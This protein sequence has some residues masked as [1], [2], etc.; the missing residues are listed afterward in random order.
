MLTIKR[1]QIGWNNACEVFQQEITGILTR[2]EALDER[3]RDL[4]LEYW[5]GMMVLRRMT[6][7][8]LNVYRFHREFFLVSFKNFR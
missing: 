2:T 6:Q 3:G 4:I 5:K 7:R 1:M 8:F